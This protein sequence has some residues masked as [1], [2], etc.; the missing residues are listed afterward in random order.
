MC[1][2]LKNWVTNLIIEDDYEGTIIA[3]A[4]VDRI[5]LQFICKSLK[6]EISHGSLLQLHQGLP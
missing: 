4:Q 1:F 2:F 5:G 3:S 6:L